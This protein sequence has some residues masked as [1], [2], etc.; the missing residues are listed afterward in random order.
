MA[1]LTGR[2]NV[3]A[4]RFGVK[5]PKEFG[6]V[7]EVRCSQLDFTSYIFEGLGWEQWPQ[8]LGINDFGVCRAQG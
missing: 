6:E 1:I 5:Y 7:V 8:P 3:V 4:K 2:E